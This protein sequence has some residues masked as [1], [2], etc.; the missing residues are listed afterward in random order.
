MQAAVLGRMP[1]GSQ[2]G[3]LRC[4]VID[5]R[6]GTVTRAVGTADPFISA[7][8]ASFPLVAALAQ[9]PDFLAYPGSYLRR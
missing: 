1:L 8:N 4:E 3:I 6:N 5:A 9:P 2:V 7:G